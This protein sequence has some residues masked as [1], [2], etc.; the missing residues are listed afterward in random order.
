MLLDQMTISSGGQLAQG[1]TLLS[2][3]GS[4]Q[5]VHLAATLGIVRV[6]IQDLRHET[7]FFDQVSNKVPLTSIIDGLREELLNQTAFKVFAGG[8]DCILQEPVRLLDFV[9]VEQIRLAEF[10]FLQVVFLHDSHTEHIGGS[11][12]PA[13]ARRTLVGDGSTLEGDLD[14]ENLTIGYGCIPVGQDARYWVVAQRRNG[15]AVLNT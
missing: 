3:L 8:I 15:E 9:P 6:R 11:E 13:S 10:K 12:Q 1:Q 7:V 5:R 4:D 2:Q 14:V